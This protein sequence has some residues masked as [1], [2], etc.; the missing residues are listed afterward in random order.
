MR[1]L[2]VALRGEARAVLNGFAC[3]D[4]VH[5][6]PTPRRDSADARVAEL[7][8]AAG[9]RLVPEARGAIPP[10]PWGYVLQHP[11]AGFLVGIARLSFNARADTAR[12]LVLKKC[13]N[14]PGYLHDVFGQDDEY[15]LVR[16]TDGRW[17]VA[18]KRMTRITG[19]EDA[20]HRHPT[21]R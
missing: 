12:V 18:G 3:F 1:A 4:G 9:A 14:P 8:R 17:Q 7:A 15:H 13:D 21:L 2:G 19:R 10:C 16:G 20:R 6:C 5:P 11:G